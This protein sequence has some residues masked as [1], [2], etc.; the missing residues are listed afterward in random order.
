MASMIGGWRMSYYILEWLGVG[1]DWG[2]RRA[3]RCVR[4]RGVAFGECASRPDDAMN[5]AQSDMIAFAE[6]SSGWDALVY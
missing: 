1:N 5:R 2:R 3:A 6:Q 4:L